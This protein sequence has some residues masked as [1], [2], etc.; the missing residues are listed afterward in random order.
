MTNNNWKEVMRTYFHLPFLAHSFVSDHASEL[1]VIQSEMAGWSWREIQSWSR[2]QKCTHSFEFYKE[3]AIDIGKFTWIEEP[4]DV[5]SIVL[6][7]TEV[8]VIELAKNAA[9]WKDV[10]IIW[11][12]WSSLQVGVHEIVC[13]H[14]LD[15]MV[16][17]TNFI[18][19]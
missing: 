2:Q 1:K 10:E 12:V 7:K 3:N 18:K 14:V 15:T 5:D 8:L 9:E 13:M 16:A 11:H 17:K 19:V 4:A 6:N